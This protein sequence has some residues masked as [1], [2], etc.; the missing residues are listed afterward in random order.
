MKDFFRKYLN[1][2]IKLEK[3]QII[4]T[5]CLVIVVS[6]MFGWLYEFIFYFFNSGMK[7]FYLRGANF[8]PWINI[9][10][11]GSIMII[12]LTRNLKKY[13]I[14][15]FLIAF[16]STGILEYF[17]GYF[18]Y[19]LMNGIRCWDYNTEILNFGNI[20]GFVCLR[21]VTFFGL[22]AL[23]LMYFLLPIFMYLSIKMNKKTFIILS[24]SICALFLFDEFYNLIFAKIL[25][26]PRATNIYR[27]IGFDYMNYYKNR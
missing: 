24:V 5:I 1:D 23:F 15:I 6:G 4:G 3:W 14:L 13:P 10:A 19:K 26:A 20:D 18:M 27:K 22:S 17:S 21:S 9:Y 8:L 16:I 12:L 7:K 11:T 2:E 25:N